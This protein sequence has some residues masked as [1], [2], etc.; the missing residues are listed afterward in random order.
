LRRRDEAAFNQFVRTH[1]AT[2][3]RLLVRLLGD[4]AE[5]ED[6]AQEVFVS[7]FKA[8][9]DFRG[10][11]ALATW[12][13]RI[14]HNHAINRI[15]YRARRAS[16]AQRPLDERMQVPALGALG[17]PPALP[18]ALLEAQQ[19]ERDVRRALLMLEDEQRLLVSLR[20]IQ[21]S[22][23]E[24]IRQLTGLPIGTIKSKLHR[25]RSALHRH[26]LDLRGQS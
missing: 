3:Y 14:A 7:A 21:H 8:I 20:D 4:G 23:Y 12:L 15:K 18:D 11:A 5:A 26:F 16:D 22:S 25:A 24:Q 1:Q 13:Y 17:A 19:A 6:V 10:D 2:I 9:G